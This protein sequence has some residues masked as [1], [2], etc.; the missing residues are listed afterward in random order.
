MKLPEKGDK[1]YIPSSW[2]ISRG[3]DD[4]AG[5]LAT[6][7]KVIVDE[8]LGEDHMNGVMVE[9]EEVPSTRYNYKVLLEKQEK[10]KEQFGNQIARPDPDIDTPWIQPG[11]MV[12]YSAINSQW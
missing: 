1:I 4:V 10:L 12:F 2:H 8:R 11:D 7:S 6:I 9:F 5:G 3:S